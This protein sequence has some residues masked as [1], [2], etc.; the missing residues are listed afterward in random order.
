MDERLI[1]AV[2][3]AY[4]AVRAAYSLGYG[5]GYAK[6]R[7][8]AEAAQKVYPGAAGPQHAAPTYISGSSDRV[9]L[10]SEMPTRHI[11]NVLNTTSW[12]AV[13]GLEKALRT[14]LARRGERA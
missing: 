4:A 12:R 5:A 13:Q 1:Q 9:Y 6:G 8:A 3:Q 2:E 10:I 11:V 14:E 7:D